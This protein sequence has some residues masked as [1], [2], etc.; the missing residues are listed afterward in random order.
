MKFAARK[1]WIAYA[2]TAAGVIIEIL[3]THAIIQGPEA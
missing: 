1:G 2:V 3:L